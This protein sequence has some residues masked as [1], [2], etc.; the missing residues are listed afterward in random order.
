MRVIVHGPA[1]AALVRDPEGEK[2]T[3]VELEVDEVGPSL[4]Y[5]T[6][7]V[8]KATA[9]AAAAA[10]AAAAARRRLRRRRP[11]G[12]RRPAA[13]A[14]RRRSSDDPARLPASPPCDGS[15]LRRTALL[16]TQTARSPTG[17]PRWPSHRF[18]SRRRRSVAFCKDKIAYIDYKDTTLLRKFIS[19]RGKI[20]ARR[21]TGNCIQHQRDIAMAVKNARE[22]A[23]LPYTSAPRAEEGTR[24]E[25]HPHPGGRPGSARPATSSRSRTATAA[26]TSCP[27]GCAISWTK[28]GEKQI[29][30][31][32]RA[33][34]VREIRDLGHAQEIKAELEALT[35]TL[36]ARAGDGG[37]LFG[38]VTAADSPTA[39]KPA[40]GPTLDK[41]RIELGQRASRPSARTRCPSRLHPEVDRDGHVEVVPTA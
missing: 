4:R 5:A 6:A 11:V 9:A 39:V 26:T 35:V 23:L 30:Q 13:A 37:R 7:K 1:Q 38:S 10:S 40:G 41:R 27:R 14:P 17:A 24:H 34:E 16:I 18:A 25:A 36:T 28:G 3:V 32:K 12:Q 20:R 8:T 15:V 22:M 19:D 2:R 31:I 21:V 29:A 33:R